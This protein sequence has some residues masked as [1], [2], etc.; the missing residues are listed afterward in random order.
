MHNTTTVNKSLFK[1]A[2]I[3]YFFKFLVFMPLLYYF[4]IF[5]IAITDSNGQLYSSFLDNYLNYISWLRFSIL[6]TANWIVQGFELTSY[7]S[8]IYTLSV[9]QGPGV[10]IGYTCLGYGVMSFWI[11]FILAQDDNW[12]KKATWCLVGVVGIWFINCWRVA[13]LLIALAKEWEVN[14][15]IN[16]HDMFNVVVYA[17]IIMLIY[18][19]YKQGE[20]G[21]Q[22][23]KKSTTNLK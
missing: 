23:H 5:Y 19:Y 22:L 8:D 6:H 16:H 4:N 21:L 1:H 7:I 15:Y 11:A 20:K 3:A 9:L 2:E 10:I 14:K 17:L 18:M 13:I 12:Q